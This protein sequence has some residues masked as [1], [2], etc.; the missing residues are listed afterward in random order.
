MQSKRVADR[1]DNVDVRRA[2]VVPSCELRTESEKHCGQVV[3]HL[4]W[5]GTALVEMYDAGAEHAV[6]MELLDQVVSIIRRKR[7]LD[8]RLREIASLIHG[9]RRTPDG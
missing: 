9:W 6:K 2:R 7:R 3:P 1:S 8:E 5:L 4:D